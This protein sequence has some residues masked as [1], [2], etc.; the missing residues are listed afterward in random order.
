MGFIQMDKLLYRSV[1]AWLILLNN[2]MTDMEH[3]F[4]IIVIDRASVIT[5]ILQV[6]TETLFM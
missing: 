6:M 2:M 5:I 1:S 3:V 4:L